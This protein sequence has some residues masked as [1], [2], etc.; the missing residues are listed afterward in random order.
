MARRRRKYKLR[1]PRKNPDHREPPLP[2]WFY[3]APLGTCRWCGNPTLRPDG[4]LRAKANWHQEC[5]DPYFIIT[6]QSYAK[7]AVNKRDKGICAKCGKVCKSKKEWQLDHIVA[8]KDIPEKDV[9]YW[10]MGNLQIQCLDC[11]KKKTT[12]ENSK[13]RNAKKQDAKKATKR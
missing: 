3:T 6:R 5:L 1:K 7:K 13:R 4:T 11:H 12:E 8:L 10:G 2:S 9:K